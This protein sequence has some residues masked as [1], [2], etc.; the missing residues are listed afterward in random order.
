MT[1]KLRK[2]YAKVRKA[3]LA[4]IVGQSASISLDIAR[5]LEQW[6]H[7]EASGLVRIILEE[8]YSPDVSYLDTW[9]H[10]SE[11]SKKRMIDDIYQKGIVVVVGQYRNSEDTAWEWA[12]SVGDCQGYDNAADPFQ[13]AYVP[14]I[15]RATIDALKQSLRD[16][17]CTHCGHRQV[18]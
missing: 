3:G 13:N 4:C 12:D 10:L 17:F 2:L 9:E 8:E 1:T 14:D 5:T 18:A 7:L 16:R 11:Q 15:M 6:Q